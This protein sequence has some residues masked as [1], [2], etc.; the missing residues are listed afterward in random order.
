MRR[1]SIPWRG[2]CRLWPRGLSVPWRHPALAGVSA[3]YSGPRGRL[4]TCY[5]PVR[6]SCIAA[7][8]R[9]A[10]I[11]HAAGVYPE[12]GSNSQCFIIEAAPG[13]RLCDLYCDPSSYDTGR[14]I[15]YDSWYVSYYFLPQCELTYYLVIFI[16]YDC[17]YW[18][19]RSVF[20]EQSYPRHFWRLLMILLPSLRCKTFFENFHFFLHLVQM[21]IFR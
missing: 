10:C 9:L 14:R 17:M 8:V 19:S 12:P 18:S 5:S 15:R 4:P 16:F 20:K 21:S 3:W 11:R 7:L 2:S 13:S 6:H 1:R